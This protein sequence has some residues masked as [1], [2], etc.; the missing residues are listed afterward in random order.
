MGQNWIPY[1]KGIFCAK[2]LAAAEL[3]MFLALLFQL[4]NQY[5]LLVWVLKQG[6]MFFFI[7][8]SIAWEVDNPQFKQISLKG[9][10]AACL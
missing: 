5:F 6:S 8:F 7:I 2:Y 3:S 1:I 9:I 4:K 10:L